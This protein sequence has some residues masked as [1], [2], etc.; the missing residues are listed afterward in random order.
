MGRIKWNQT[1]LAGRADRAAPRTAPSPSA[2]TYTHLLA[3][4]FTFNF[5]LAFLLTHAMKMYMFM[6]IQRNLTS[7][8]LF[9]LDPETSWRSSHLRLQ[10]RRSTR[11]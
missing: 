8:H 10:S 11:S 1:A 2:C 4:A 9:L 3:V 5:Q 7:I 6:I